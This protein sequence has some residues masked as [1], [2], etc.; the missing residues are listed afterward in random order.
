MSNN[1]NVLTELGGD[2]PV[3][4]DPIINAALN[5]FIIQFVDDI[6]EIGGESRATMATLE[7]MKEDLVHAIS[8]VCREH[9]EQA[10]WEALKLKLACKSNAAMV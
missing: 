4:P 7:L 1:L 5:H 8:S 6:E 2:Q 10:Q 9:S 3:H